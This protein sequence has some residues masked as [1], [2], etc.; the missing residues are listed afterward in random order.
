MEQNSERIAFSGKIYLTDATFAP[1]PTRFGSDDGGD[2]NVRFG[3]LEEPLLG[4]KALQFVEGKLYISTYVMGSKEQDP[5]VIDPRQSIGGTYLKGV[6]PSQS[7]DGI[8]LKRSH[9]N[10]KK[11][12]RVKAKKGQVPA[13][14]LIAP[15]S[16]VPPSTLPLPAKP[17]EKIMTVA[18]STEVTTDEIPITSQPPIVEDTQEEVTNS[19]TMDKGKK[20]LD[21]KKGKL[22]SPLGDTSQ[23]TQQ[24]QSFKIGV[25]TQS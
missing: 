20:H 25:I 21:K 2:P 17:K 6:D 16:T 11:R 3:T 13:S 22:D 23:G 7:K 8:H 15:S 18:P 4:R 5:S 24:N 14:S 1:L 19:T 10:P 12:V 9:A